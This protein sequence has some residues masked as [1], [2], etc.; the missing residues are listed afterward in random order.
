MFSNAN[1]S[2]IASSRTWI[3][4]LVVLALFTLAGAPGAEAAPT[5]TIDAGPSDP[6]NDQTPSFTFTVSGTTG[7]VDI[8]C[9][10][11]AGSYSDCTSCLLYTSDAAD[12]G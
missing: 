5:V 3:F 10:M 6:S 1:L 8:E 4:A 7:E 2:K 11:A 12:E 9:A